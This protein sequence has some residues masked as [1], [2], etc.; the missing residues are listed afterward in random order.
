[1]KK[2]ILKT[3]KNAMIF[4]FVIAS[5]IFGQHLCAQ[6]SKSNGLFEIISF[7]NDTVKL[8]IVEETKLYSVALTDG[9]QI[10]EAKMASNPTDTVR[11]PNG[12]KWLPNSKF[13]MSMLNVA[14]LS[15][16]FVL[17][18]YD[19]ECPENFEATEIRF[20]TEKGTTEIYYDI[21]KSLW[22]E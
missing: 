7:S 15:K 21:L 11:W 10:F 5:A 16:G 3:Q 6:S 22:G 19:F 8:K 2:K 9:N 14:V 1:M 13:P 12:A 17:T 18:V 20:I 4:T